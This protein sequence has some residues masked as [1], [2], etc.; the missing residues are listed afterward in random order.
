LKHGAGALSR[1]A[2]DKLFCFIITKAEGPILPSS[3]LI[4]DDGIDNDDD[5]LVDSED[6]DCLPAADPCLENPELPD[7]P[8]PI[9]PCIENPDLPECQPIDPCIENP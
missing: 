8:P 5:G 3:E 1:T 4:C 6:P 9:D 7:C 2:F